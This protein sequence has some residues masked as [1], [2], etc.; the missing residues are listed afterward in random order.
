MILTSRMNSYQTNKCIIEMNKIA[1]L[2]E[3]AILSW[4]NY[5]LAEKIG[6]QPNRNL[7]PGA[8]KY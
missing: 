4:V 5:V 1:N 2:K 6:F 3:V 8:D 7:F